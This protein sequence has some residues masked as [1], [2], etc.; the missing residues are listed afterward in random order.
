M[1]QPDLFTF[2]GLFSRNVVEPRMLGMGLASKPKY[3]FAISYPDPQSLPLQG[4]ATAVQQALAEEGPDLALYLSTQGYGPLREFI[5]A[6]LARD[7]QIQ[8]SAEELVITSGAGQAIHIT[9]ESL[10]D[11]GD[12]ILTDDFTYGGALHQMRRFQAEIRGVPTDEEGVLPDA[13][14]QTIRRLTHAGKRPKLFYT[15]PTFQNPLGWTLSLARR[16]ALVELAQKYGMPILEDDCY[17]D[18]RYDGQELP[19]LYTLDGSGHVIYVSS[20]SKTIAPGMRTGYMTAAPALLKRA[21]AA[22]SGGPVPLFVTLA[23]HRF[24]TDPQ[25]GGL[26]SHIETINDIQRQRRDAMLSSLAEHFTDGAT[27]VRPE[28]GLSVWVRFPE[29]VDASS[30]RE[31]IFTATNVGYATG[32]TFAPDR[33]TGKNCIRLSFGFNTPTEIQ[34]G[35]ALLADAFRHE[36]LLPQ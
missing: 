30:I 17:A 25:Q 19:S 31:K 7:R 11:P 18:L 32:P 15:V 22:K 26:A 1:S 29:G 2:D 13:L 27:W 3:D 35:M 21:M 5:A 24:A 28:G 12:I 9:L 20:F 10:V 34:T 6:K 16:R 14:E 33:T 4:L 36:G 23:I 8:V